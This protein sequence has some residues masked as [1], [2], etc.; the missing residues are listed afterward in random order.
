MIVRT[1]PSYGDTGQVVAAVEPVAASRARDPAPINAER[2]SC[3]ELKDSLHSAGALT[4]LSGE[5]G[6]GD[7]Y[8]GPRVPQC[9]FWQRPVFS[10][11][12]TTD[13]RCGVGYICVEKFSGG[14]GGR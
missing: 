11:V 1:T 9:Q 14:G 3:K 13:G 4:I 12:N 5:K 2:V 6:W 7:T 10:Y 8:F